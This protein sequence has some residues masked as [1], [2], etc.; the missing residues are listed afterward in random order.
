VYTGFIAADPG[1]RPGALIADLRVTEIAP[2]VAKLL[3]MAFK[4]PEGKIVHG[5]LVNNK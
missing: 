2:L 5:I 3:G 4:T 1:I